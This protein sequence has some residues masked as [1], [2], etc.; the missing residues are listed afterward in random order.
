MLIQYDISCY[1]C[2]SIMHESKADAI[3]YR[4][5]TIIMINQVYRSR[6]LIVDRIAHSHSK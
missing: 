6:N 2:N 1:H 4:R 5:A 3:V